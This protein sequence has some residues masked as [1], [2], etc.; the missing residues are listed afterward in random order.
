MARWCHIS[1]L[2]ITGALLAGCAALQPRSGTGSGESYAWVPGRWNALSGGRGFALRPDGSFEG[3]EITVNRMYLYDKRMPEAA[4]VDEAEL[5]HRRIS[6]TYE[7]VRYNRYRER[8][9]DW[10]Y[11]S[12]YGFTQKRLRRLVDTHGLK[13]FRRF[14]ILTLSY[15]GVERR[16]VAATPW[17]DRKLALVKDWDSRHP[18][19]EALV[20]E[21]TGS[22]DRG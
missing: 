19:R 9:D 22:M 4:Y 3:F 14:W 5:S 13:D 17:G 2:A 15:G 6:G 10:R 18:F 16:Y 8:G 7:V 20:F 11:G 21:Y 1:V 12:P